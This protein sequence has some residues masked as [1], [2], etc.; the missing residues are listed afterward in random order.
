[1]VIIFSD[2]NLHSLQLEAYCFHVSAFRHRFRQ[3]K[4]TMYRQAKGHCFCL[5]RNRSKPNRKEGTLLL[6]IYI[7]EKRRKDVFIINR[8][9]TQCCKECRRQ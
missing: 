7:E 8:R 9:N 3:Y 5:R 2:E 1:M 6:Y 4:E